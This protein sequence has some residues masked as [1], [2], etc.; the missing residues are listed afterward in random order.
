MAMSPR[1]AGSLGLIGIAGVSACLWS[2]FRGP[3]IS[4]SLDSVDYKDLRF[5]FR[6]S[7]INS[8]RGVDVWSETKKEFLWSISLGYLPT[9]PI[10]KEPMKYGELPAVAKQSFP[11]NGARPRG[12]EPGERFV[13]EVHYQYDEWIAA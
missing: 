1:A 4:V 5:R 8:I 12:L 7:R 6:T 11:K 2:A 13:V 9:E 10:K 3:S